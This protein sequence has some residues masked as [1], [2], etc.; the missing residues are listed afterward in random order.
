MLFL[1][2]LHLI[3]AYWLYDLCYQHSFHNVFQ[4]AWVLF[5]SQRIF[6]LCFFS[7]FL[8]KLMVYFLILYFKFSQY[9]WSTRIF[10]LKRSFKVSEITFFYLVNIFLVFYEAVIKFPKTTTSFIFFLVGEQLRGKLKR[11]CF[12]RDLYGIR[13][14]KIIRRLWIKPKK[15]FC[16]KVYLL[17]LGIFI[18]QMSHKSNF[19]LILISLAIDFFFGVGL[20]PY[21]SRY[22]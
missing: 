13:N 1:C 2:I 10:L 19:F 7:S 21:E 18:L 14:V 20:P 16:G 4:I 17:V 3:V 22:V 8:E 5:L 15:Y 11:Q 12:G 6:Y 9:T